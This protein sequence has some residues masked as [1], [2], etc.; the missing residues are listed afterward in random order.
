MSTARS[1]GPPNSST[2]MSSAPMC[3]SRPRSR[4]GASSARARSDFRFLH[5]STDEV[6]GALTRRRT[7]HRGDP[8]RSALALFGDQGG[9]GPSGPGLG[10]Y[11]RAPDPA[12]Q[13]L[14]QL[15][16][17]S[18]PGKAD[19]V[20]DHQGARR[21]TDAGLRPRA[22]CSRLAV[23][24]RSCAGIDAGAGTRPRGRDL[25][26]RRQRRAAQHRCG[27]ARSAMRWISSRHARTARRIASSSPSCPIAPGTISAMRS[28]SRKLNAELGWSPKHSFE[29]GLLATVK[30]YLDN[31]AWWEPLLSA[32]DA[33]CRRGLSKKSA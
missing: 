32:H 9:V 8:L 24:R 19:P 15:R 30:W 3:C 25:Q 28:T 6:Y 29:A 31:R 14:E 13:L 27:A 26:H 33:S 10:P 16:T 20:D 18:I 21:R 12:H 7:L 2:P 5:V 22:Q 4:I 17:A 1:T 11:L 23:R